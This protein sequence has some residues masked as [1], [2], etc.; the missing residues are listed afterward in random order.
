MKQ[1]PRS[2]RITRAAV[3]IV[4]LGASAALA[5]TG[6]AVDD[7]PSATGEAEPIIIGIVTS[8]SGPYA[9]QGESFINGFEAGI[10]FI[11]DG[12]GVIDGHPIDVRIGN[13]NGDPAT[14]TAAAR[15]L[16]GAGAK[17]LIGPTNSAVAVPVA[18]IAV[19]NGGTYI[20]GA[21]GSSALLGK[22][23][24]IFVTG[25]G[26][27]MP[28]QAIFAEADDAQVMAF[29]GQDYQFGQDQA[30]LLTALG[31]EKGIDVQSV[32]LPS[33]TQDFTAGVLQLKSIGADMVYVG[34]QGDGTAQLYQALADQG[35]YDSTRIVTT[36]TSR[37]AIPGFVAAAGDSAD[38]TIV[39]TSYFRGLG[40]GN[41]LE[42]AMLDY[43]DSTGVEVD[44]VHP[45]GFTAALMIERAILETDGE[46]DQAGVASALEDWTFE[47]PWGEVWIRPED[48]LITVP[49]YSVNYE[50]DGDEISATLLTTFPGLDIAPP[51]TTPLG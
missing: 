27:W 50:V 26:S 23:H 13:D 44:Y 49:M 19:E 39:L 10:D 25:S 47:S 15:D 29:I 43:A 24:N 32:L 42:T 34:W 48:H 20:A 45:Q 33:E 40:G 2:P 5:L 31:A 12:T 51:V 28:N 37:P 9:S 17:F 36:L 4:A 18:E 30:A 6:C 41:D 46:L 21:S 3:A 16:M 11:T 7:T 8:T 35:V 38:E 14:G 22:D 1:S